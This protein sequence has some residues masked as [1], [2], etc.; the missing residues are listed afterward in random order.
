MSKICYKSNKDTETKKSVWSTIM[1]Q[2]IIMK[3]IM[4]SLMCSLATLNN[5][6]ASFWRSGNI[7]LTSRVKDNPQLRKKFLK[8]HEYIHYGELL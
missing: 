4:L 8:P 7:I 2:N 6:K 5:V 1:Y 3:W